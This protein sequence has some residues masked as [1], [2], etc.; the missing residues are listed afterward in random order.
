LKQHLGHG[1]ENIKPC[2]KPKQKSF[3]NRGR[4]SGSIHNGTK[5]QI[6]SFKKSS[7]FP[8]DDHI[9]YIVPTQ[10]HP[11]EEI[12]VDLGPS[13]LKRVHRLDSFFVPHTTP[14]SQPTIDAK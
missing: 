11:T 10:N 12:V 5:D 9:S 1:R 3:K 14:V 7:N 6:P 8:I 2:Q 13:N 4:I